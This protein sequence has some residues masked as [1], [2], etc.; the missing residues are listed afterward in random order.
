MDSVVKLE[1]TDE[2]VNQAFELAM[3]SSDCSLKAIKEQVKILV[4]RALSECSASPDLLSAATEFLTFAG[5]ALDA[6]AEVFCPEEFEKKMEGLQTRFCQR[7][8]KAK[9]NR[10]E[11][12]R[13]R[14]ELNIIKGNKQLVKTLWDK[15]QARYR[16]VLDIGDYSCDGHEKDVLFLVEADRDVEAA[17]EAH[18]KIQSVTGVDISSFCNEAEDTLLPDAVWEKMRELGFEFPPLYEDDLGKHLM[19]KDAAD[20]PE[21]M[22]EMWVF[23]L[24]QVDGELNATILPEQDYAHLLECGKGLHSVGYGL[25]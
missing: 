5:D 1:L 3:F 2:Q 25:V 8:M 7:F 24:N 23:L 11:I 6:T 17:R 18:R 21:L 10:K 22:A 4:R 13:I 15:R 19:A 12:Q 20:L 9:R 14:D 16:F